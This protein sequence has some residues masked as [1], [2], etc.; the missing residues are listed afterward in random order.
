MDTY[1]WDI[2]GERASA[3]AGE[4]AVESGPIT[5]CRSYGVI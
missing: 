4:E 3:R 2:L 1:C 5:P